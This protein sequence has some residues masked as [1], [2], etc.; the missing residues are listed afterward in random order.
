MKFSEAFGLNKIQAE[1]DFVD[2]EVDGDTPLYVDP[3]ALSIRKDDVGRTSLA[4]SD[5]GRCAARAR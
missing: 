4:R 5:P 3:F 2:I 1:L